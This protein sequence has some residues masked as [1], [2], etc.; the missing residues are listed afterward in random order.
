[1]LPLKG[2]RVLDLTTI[3]PFTTTEFA[4][5]GAEVIKVERPGSGDTIRAY[6][7]FQEG[8]SA[9]HCYTDRGKKSITLNLRDDQGKEILK[10]LIKDADILVEN[11]KAGT[12]EK[13]GLGYEVLAEL[14]PALVYG[15][16]SS[17]GDVGPQREYIAYDIAVQ[18]QC[19]IMDATGYPDDEPSRVGCYVSDHLSCTYLGSAIV[20]ALYHAKKTGQ[21][22]RVEVSMYESVLSVMAEKVAA[23][24]AGGNPSRTGHLH[25]SFAPYDM[26]PCQNGYVALAVTSD[27]QW[28]GLCSSFPEASWAKEASY[29]TNQGR[30][31]AYLTELREALCASFAELSR[32]DIVHRCTQ[33][34]VPASPVHTM[35]EA[36]ASPQ[37]EARHMLPVVTHQTVGSVPTVGKVIHYGDQTRPSSY[38]TAPLLGEHNQDIIGQALL[39]QLSQQG[40]I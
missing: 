6:P 16:L 3:N 15:K 40:V 20:L 1:M 22:Q 18:A 21:G 10:A 9:Y 26:L 35:E 19:G 13:M 32:E 8:V 23:L 4:D 33:A 27:A 11:F 29:A 25:H 34:K 28:E 24:N 5:Y 36:I 31:E 37:M 39:E 7:P 38:T 2:V 12:M 17:Y 30:Q 14:N